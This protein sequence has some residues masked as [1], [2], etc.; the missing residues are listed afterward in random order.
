MDNTTLLIDVDPKL[1]DEWLYEKN[2]GL[3]PK[4]YRV[5]SSKKVWWQCLENKKHQWEATIYHRAIDGTGCPYCSGLKTLREDSFGFNYPE[6]IKELHPSKNGTF[7]PFT[8]SP[9]SNKKIWWKCSKNPKHVWRTAIKARTQGGTGCRQCNNLNNP[10]SKVRPDLVNEWHPTLN[11]LSP[12][13]VSMGSKKIVWWQCSKNKDHVWKTQASTRMRGNAGSCPK[14]RTTKK[15]NH[16]IPLAEHSPELVS[17]WHPKKNG[18]L[19]PEDVNASSRRKIWWV[20]P[21]NPEHEWEASVR[22]RAVLHSGCPSCSR[23]SSCPKPGES[24]AD[25]FPDLAKEWHPDKNGE[26]TPYDVKRGSSKRVWWQCLK[27]PDHVWDATVCSRTSARSKHR[28]PFCSGHKVNESNS[29]A[30]IFPAIAKEWHAEKNGDLS[31]DQIKKASGRVVWWQCSKNPNHSWQTKVKNRTLLGSG[32]PICNSIRLQEGL[33]DSALSNAD[34]LKTFNNSLSAIRSILNHPFPEK[35]RL[36]Q[37]LYRMLYTA[38]ITA[39][40]TY[41]S[42][43]FIQNVLG[44]HDKVILLMTTDPEFTKRSYSIN[45]IIDLHANA[46][47]KAKEYLLDIVW[48]NL[49]KVRNLYRTVLGVCFPREMDSVFRS[50]IARHDLVHRNGK[51]KDG[52]PLRLKKNDLEDLFDDINEFVAHINTQVENFKKQDTT[53]ACTLSQAPP[54]Q[55]DA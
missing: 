30:A 39:M 42:D 9:H 54:A 36:T 43:T 16:Q 29:L 45:D 23:F 18:T 14:C 12:D 21:Q 48:H 51:K 6:L 41:L 15:G 34:S 44:N 32:C 28:C 13:E 26:L 11:E 33:K 4:D 31:P 40:E 52:A 47:K 2:V 8:V 50:V 27:N 24:F 46:Q 7:N 35:P 19:K 17:Q 37:S 5:N 25:H 20:C 55:S 49:S 1:L 3:S 10:I 53:I 22:N 38:T